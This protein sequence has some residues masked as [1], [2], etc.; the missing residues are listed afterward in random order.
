[1]SNEP[2]DLRRSPGD[3]LDRE[4]GVDLTG[5]ES[6]F[7]KVERAKQEWEATADSLP[8]LVCVVDVH[9]RVIR[10]NRTLETW[11]LGDV[12]AIQG[13]G[14]HTLLHPGCLGLYCPLDRYLRQQLGHRQVEPL[15]SFE[16]YDTFLQRYVQVRVRPI[17][18][19]HQNLPVSAVVV[20]ED[21]TE[22]RHN[23]AALQRSLARLA[24]LNDIQRAILMARSPEEIATAAL[25]H[26]RPLVVFRQARVTL[27]NT[28]ADG[29]VMLTAEANGSTHLRPSHTCTGA[30][31]QFD[32]H[33]NWLQEFCVDDIWLIDQPTRLERQL[34][35]EGQRSLV[36]VPLVA[37]GQ[38]VG[39]LLLASDRVA[40]FRPEQL[41][42]AREICDL[43]AIAAYQAQLYHQVQLSNAQLRDALRVKSE[44]VSNVSH[45]LRTPLGVIYGY[46][47][48]LEE[49]NLGPVVPDQRQALT[50]ML[51]HEE[52]LR[53][54][55]DRLVDLRTIDMTQ[56][57]R[58]PLDVADWLAVVL[59]PWQARAALAAHPLEVEV[60]LPTP[61][62]PLSADGELL[63]QIM[64]NLLDNAF[65]FS[66]PGAAIRVAA[67]IDRDVVLMAVQDYGVGLLSDQIEHVFEQFYQVDGSVTR[68]FG[69]MGVGLALCRE[70]VEAHGGRI[71]VESAGQ[72]QGSTFW[73]ALPLDAVEGSG[74]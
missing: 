69:G 6:I 25:M 59:R 12:K 36:N 74:N 57:C 30:D 60:D 64:D 17:V 2:I 43:L 40:A 68:R 73:C 9:G 62:P 55:V 63:K 52:Q 32:G 34:I 3:L 19:Q 66:P 10:T 56:L 48:L 53:F 7:E 38:C 29:F 61:Q 26:L 13:F 46:T 21:I 71:W 16:G 42:V 54:M 20:V 15:E 47:A 65:K 18:T 31:L 37:D 67:K 35:D 72:G 50:V 27:Q 1:M 24:A 45:E 5:T 14:L 4:A 28:D 44:L 41:E 22:R 8:E 51:K 33:R 11:Q 23:E 49:G 39:A 70:I 58:Q